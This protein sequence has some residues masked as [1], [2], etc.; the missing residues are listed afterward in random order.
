MRRHPTIDRETEDASNG[1]PEAARRAAC[2]GPMLVLAGC[3]SV[4]KGGTEAILDL[5]EREDTRKCHVTGPASTGLATVLETQEQR[6]AGGQAEPTLKI[7]MVHGIGRH[8]PGY[9]ARLTEHLKRALALDVTTERPKEIALRS[10]QF[11]D[12]PMGF[13][14]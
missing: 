3:S 2:L 11:P 4:T 13:L 10:S 7:L 1:T 12:Q 8:L 6:R 9:S 14:S 5:A